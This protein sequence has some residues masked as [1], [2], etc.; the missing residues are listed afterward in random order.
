MQYLLESQCVCLHVV[1][2]TEAP[3]DD[4]PRGDVRKCGLK[5]IHFELLSEKKKVSCTSQLLHPV[6][7][8]SCA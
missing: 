1:D 5:M 2:N 3:S 7:S 4:L 8:P 6:A